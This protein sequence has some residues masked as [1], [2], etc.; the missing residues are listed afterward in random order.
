MATYTFT[1]GTANNIWGHSGN[2]SPSGIPTA[3]DDAIFSSAS[4][5]VTINSTSSCLGLNFQSGYTGTVTFANSG[6]CDIL[7]GASGLTLSSGMG[8]TYTFPVS[9]FNGVFRSTFTIQTQ[10]TNGT[11]SITTNGKTIPRLQLGLSKIGTVNNLVINGTCTVSEAMYFAYTYGS[12]LGCADT[13]R[14]LGGTVS[15]IGGSFYSLAR[16][17]GNST[18]LLNPPPGATLSFQGGFANGVNGWS[19][20]TV[21]NAPGATVNI[22]GYHEL[23][24]GGS[25]Y[26]VAGNA[27]VSSTHQ[28]AIAGVGN[29]IST[30]GMTWGRF[31]A[32]GFPGWWGS[33]CSLTSL[34]NLEVGGNQAVF[35]GNSITF[36]TSGNRLILS[37]SKVTP[38]SGATYTI[39]GFSTDLLIS[40]TGERN[41]NG[42]PA[43]AWTNGRFE[44]NMS[45]GTCN[46]LYPGGAASSFI[47][48]TGSTFTS[49]TVNRINAANAGFI[50]T[51]PTGPSMN[52]PG[53]TIGTGALNSNSRVN[54]NAPI[55]FN[56][57]SS[58]TNSY[59]AGSSG[60]TANT[61][62]PNAGGVG[63][64]FKAGLTYSVASQFNL[65][66]SVSSRIALASDT[67][68]DFTGTISGNVLTVSSGSGLTAGMI[69]S[70]RSGTIPFGLAEILPDRPVIVSGSGP[71]IISPA[72]TTAVTPAIAMAAGSPAYLT[73]LPGASHNVLWA[74]TQDIN[75]FYGSPVFAFD[76]FNDSAGVTSP[77][78]YRTVNW[79]PLVPPGLPLAQTFC[80]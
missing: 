32:G 1:G 17:I 25:F 22:D 38:G 31:Y 50:F 18:I 2:W 79:G 46:F 71:Y 76:S 75:S 78:L 13:Q 42:G 27:N 16:V 21:I 72:L 67:R 7:V 43:S 73:L 70:Q 48:G 56:N 68:V 64:I 36:P 62:T 37:G 23:R 30:D 47:W 9:G 41:I 45:S 54:I 29:T 59:F 28:L 14:F 26:Y 57:V 24:D 35:Y 4:P 40:G 51:S 39:S 66:G 49:S 69:I 3:A 34:G 44:I 80:S 20:P 12:G 55:Y 58:G 15:I 77:S 19:I 52:V 63:T 5:G 6:A 61:F 11:S 65:I 60:W 33:N 53:L 74:T 10:P 8:I